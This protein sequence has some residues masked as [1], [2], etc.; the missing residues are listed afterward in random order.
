MATENDEV[1]AIELQLQFVQSEIDE[2]QENINKLRNQ[3]DAL[4]LKKSK[5]E[6]RLDNIIHNK[7]QADW[8]SSD[9][10]WTT[11][12]DACLQETF[13]MPSLR[14]LQRETINATL[15]GEDCMLIM[16]TGG[17]KSLCFQLPALLG[18]GFTLVYHCFLI[19]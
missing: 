13:K 3:Q 18:S 7:N 14:P 5:L 10:P 4:K 6:K 1:A 9:F 11:Q 16:P 19:Y 17:G 15:S 12:I 2:I 8:S